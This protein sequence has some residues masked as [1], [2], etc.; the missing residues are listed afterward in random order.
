VSKHAPPMAFI[1]F[2]AILL[3][4]FALTTTGWA[5]KNPFPSTLKNPALVTSMTGILSVF[6]AANCLEFYVNKDHNLSR[7]M[8]GAWSLFLF[9]WKTLIPIFP[10][11]PGWYLSIAVL[12]WVRPPA[13]P[14]P[15]ECF[16]FLPTLP[17]P[18]LTEPLSF[19]DFL[20][21]DVIILWWWFIINYYF[22]I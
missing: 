13:L 11:N 22:Y 3:K 5:G 14:L 18:Q 16:L 15:P 9:K 6:L 21:L 10:K 8:D 4:N 20:S 2:S 17:P 1:F 12:L 7:L 19:L